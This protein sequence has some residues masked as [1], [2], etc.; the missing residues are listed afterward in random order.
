MS[1]SLVCAVIDYFDIVDTIRYYISKS[2]IVCFGCESE[3]PVEHLEFVVHS[4][5]EMDRALRLNLVVESCVSSSVNGR[6]VQ[7]FL[8]ERSLIIQ[9][10]SETE[11][12]VLI[13]S[14]NDSE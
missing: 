2:L 14:R 5:D 11:S 1:R 13:E 8:E 6:G 3:W 4:C 12:D 9:S 10:S 7:Q